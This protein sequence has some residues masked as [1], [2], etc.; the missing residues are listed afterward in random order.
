MLN[1][2]NQLERK[3]KNGVN[4]TYKVELMPAETSI[5]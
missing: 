3:F 5:Q 1:E 4:W 2:F